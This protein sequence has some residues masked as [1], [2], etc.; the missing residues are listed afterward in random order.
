[1]YFGSLRTVLKS[2][3]SVVIIRTV[4]RALK[5]E[6]ENLDFAL[7]LKL[8]FCATLNKSLYLSESLFFPFLK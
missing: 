2:P 4:E 6:S 3:E 8:N 7:F 1:M 5:Q